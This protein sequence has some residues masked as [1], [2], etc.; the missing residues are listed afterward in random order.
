MHHSV[1]W[2][3]LALPEL[4]MSEGVVLPRT[5]LGADSDHSWGAQWGRRLMGQTLSAVGKGEQGA[6]RCCFRINNLSIIHLKIT[7][8]WQEQK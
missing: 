6:T 8:L 7:T 5:A 4:N 3:K 2:L 1:S